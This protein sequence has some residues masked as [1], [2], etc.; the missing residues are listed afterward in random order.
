M[1]PELESD[2]LIELDV[3]DTKA[4]DLCEILDDIPTE[5][6]DEVENSGIGT[7]FLLPKGYDPNAYLKE[8]N[9]KWSKQRRIEEVRVGSTVGATIPVQVGQVKCNALVDT[10]AT[11]SCIS[12]EFYQQLMQP[13]IRSLYKMTVVSATGSNVKPLGMTICE[14]L[15]GKRKFRM[16]FIVCEK[17]GRPCYLGLDFLRKY[18]IGLG[19]SPTGKFQL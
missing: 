16:D 14:I 17:V 8:V 7:E 2:P 4:G 13:Q 18:K 1:H 9:I 3:S 11:R 6:K 12:K 15:I 10:G 5:T 19:W